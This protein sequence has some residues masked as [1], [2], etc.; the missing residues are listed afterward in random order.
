[1]NFREN[2]NDLH[3][4]NLA[5]TALQYLVLYCMIEKNYCMIEKNYFAFFP[6]ENYIWNSAEPY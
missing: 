2:A 3:K 1:M 4:K 6:V 5:R